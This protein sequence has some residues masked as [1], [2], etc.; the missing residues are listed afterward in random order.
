MKTIYMGITIAMIHERTP[1]IAQQILE[2]GEV[3]E[4]EDNVKYILIDN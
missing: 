4:T 1:K 3:K 2:Q